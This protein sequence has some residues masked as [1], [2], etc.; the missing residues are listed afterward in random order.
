MKKN[1]T[2]KL[3]KCQYRSILYEIVFSSDVSIT[4]RMLQFK[5]KWRRRHIFKSCQ[6]KRNE[7]RQ[8]ADNNKAKLTCSSVFCKD[9]ALIRSNPDFWVQIVY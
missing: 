6:K 4:S 1:F 5:K 9:D 8:N 7:L 3:L 2:F